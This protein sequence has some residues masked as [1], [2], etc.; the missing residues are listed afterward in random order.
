VIDHN[1]PV[2][3]TIALVLCP[4]NMTAAYGGPNGILGDRIHQL[5]AVAWVAAHGKAFVWPNDAVVR[6]AFQYEPVQFC[7]GST[8]EEVAREVWDAGVTTVHC[9]YAEPSR[10]PEEKRAHGARVLAC[11]AVV[12]LLKAVTATAPDELDP[13]GEVP[14]WRQLYASVCPT[15][16][17]T[18]AWP[19]PPFLVPTTAQVAEAA[20]RVRSLA[21]D[22][23]VIV[24]SPLTGSPKDA[25]DRDWWPRLAREFSAGHILVPV[26]PT[27]K[28][29]AE[30]A[31]FFAGESNVTVFGADLAETASLAAVPGVH[32][33]GNDGGR[34]NVLAAAHPVGVLAAYGDWP[35]SAWAL[36]HVVARA[37]RFIDGKRAFL[38]P[39]EALRTVP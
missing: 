18:L 20:A 3:G 15:A 22:K 17:E 6:D 2:T 25:L 37:A 21:E 12:E 28:E 32:V 36:P 8:P 1:L 19:R 23:P 24:A 30:A 26:L 10:M 14:L 31:A 13:R 4:D 39:R 11:Q 16:A 35:A 38:S 29:L 34:L 27:E 5:P 9:L 7:R 33:I